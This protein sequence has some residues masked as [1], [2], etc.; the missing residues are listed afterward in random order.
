MASLGASGSADEFLARP[1]GRYFVGNGFLIWATRGAL[2]GTSMWDGFDDQ[3]AAQ[4]LSLWDRLRATRTRA[5]DVVFDGRG[6]RS[7]APSLFELFYKYVRERV[8]ELGATFHRQALIVPANFAGA[9]MGG[10][11]PMSGAAHS[12]RVF[13]DAAE[14]FGWLDARHGPRLSAEIDS[15]LAEFA[16]SSTLLGRVRAQLSAHLSS[17]PLTQTARALGLSPRTLQR[18]LRTLGTSLRAE[19]ERARIDRARQLLTGG[20]DKL[21]EVARRSGC[22][23]AGSLSRLFRRYTGETPG[24]YRRRHAK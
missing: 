17:S 16:G 22:A 6:L 13:H 10:V 15:L 8:G 11:Y 9:A 1:H 2:T 3:S 14:A 4:L 23:N 7:V 24:A 20:D 5:L 21:D 18:S 19:L 12:W